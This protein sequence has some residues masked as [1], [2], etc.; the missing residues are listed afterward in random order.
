VSAGWALAYRRYSR[1]YVDAENEARKANRG[2][3][4]GTFVKPWDWRAASPPRRTQVPVLVTSGSRG[5]DHLSST[6]E[7][8]VSLSFCGT[9]AGSMSGRRTALARGSRLH[10]GTIQRDGRAG[11]EG[12]L[13]FIVEPRLPPKARRRP[14]QNVLRTQPWLD[15]GDAANHCTTANTSVSCGAMP[16]DPET[17][18]LLDRF[19]YKGYWWAPGRSNDRVPGTLSYDPTNG[20]HLELLGHLTPLEQLGSYNRAETGLIYGF[21]MTG[22]AVTLHGNF[23][24][25]FQLRARGI[26]TERFYSR[27]AFL[28]EHIPEPETATFSSCAFRFSN[29]EEWLSAQPF[30]VNVVST[31]PPHALDVAFRA[32]PE[33]RYVLQ[34]PVAEL[35]P[36]SSFRTHD[37]RPRHYGITVQSWLVLAPGMARPLA[38]YTEA[39]AKLRNLIALCFGAP[40][41]IEGVTLLGPDSTAEQDRFRAEVLYAQSP[42]PPGGPARLPTEP[43]SLR[44]FGDAAAD[45]INAWFRIYDAIEPALNLFFAV[46]FGKSLYIDVKFLLLTQAMEALHRSTRQSLYVCQ[47]RYDDIRARIEGA[48]PSEAPKELRDRIRGILQWGNEYS[49]RRR[50]AE[51]DSGPLTKMGVARI[52]KHMRNKIVDTRNYYTHHSEDLKNKAAH[53]RE[54][55]DLVGLMKA[56]II[57]ILFDMLGVGPERIRK[58]LGQNRDLSSFVL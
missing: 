57:A 14:F 9:A 52:N 26:A 25:S 20:L 10:H 24:L 45:V 37:E 36:A 34:H 16:S 53:G 4:R 54:M 22:R 40:V 50:L 17:P 2:M 7:P 15:S 55:H 18:R 31:R 51:L 8:G 12:K 58:W 21:T 11:A 48:I 1:D 33:T 44:D 32:P 27:A 19:E 49:F 39:I 29:L 6:S 42:S 23:P 56:A 43:I 13:C 46:L 28:G 5:A 30:S 3:W 47:S 41:Y 35:K 38:W